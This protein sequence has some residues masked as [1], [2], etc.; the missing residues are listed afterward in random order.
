MRAAAVTFRG[1]GQVAVEPVDLPD[2][3]PGE[4][5]VRTAWSGISGGT[6]MLAYRGQ[7]DPDT[8]LDERLAALGGTFRYPFRFGYA[9]T[10]RVL[11]GDDGPPTGE[12]VFVF[13]P[14]Q[15]LLVVPATDVVRLPEDADLRCATLFPLV[16]TALQVQLEAGPVTGQ[17]VLVVGLGAVGLLAAL[18]LAGAGALVTGSE[19]SGWRRQ[20]AGRLGIVAVHPDELSARVRAQTAGAG[21][22]LAVELSGDPAALAG[23][24]P[25]LGHEGTVLV[26]SWYG[27]RSV[28]LPLG[29]EFHRRRLTLRSV[30]VSTIPAALTDRWTREKRRAVTRDLLRRLPLAELATTDFPF[31]SAADAYRAVDRGAAGLLHAQL[32]YD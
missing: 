16:E 28:P 1:P 26:G 15:D 5:V 14:H 29:A 11:G 22:Q 20:L 8:Q 10:G 31:V 12:P 18:L 23:L 32:R 25:L 24:L 13:H 9:C 4:L 30:Q 21:V 27:N 19:P 2:P 17:P 7:L 6:E 3:R